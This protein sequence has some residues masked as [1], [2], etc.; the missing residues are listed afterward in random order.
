VAE[1]M[2]PLSKINKEGLQTRKAIDQATVDRYCEA[3]LAGEKLPAAIVFHDGKQNH[4]GD[5][6]HRD[7][8]YAKAGKKSMPVKVKKGSFS[9]ALHYSA[10]CNDTHG[11]P[12]SIEDRRNSVRIILAEKQDRSDN[13]VAKICHVSDGLVAKI[14]A[15]EFPPSQEESSGSGSNSGTSQGGD[16]GASGS[17]N[18]TSTEKRTGADG[19]QYSARKPK[20]L[21]ERCTRNGAQRDCPF[22]KELRKGGAGKPREPGDDSDTERKGRDAAKAN[23]KPAFDWKGALDYMG[24][25][26]RFPDVI[27]RAYPSVKG[28]KEHTKVSKC[29]DE[30][31]EIVKEWKK[32]LQEA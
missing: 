18:G 10:G 1:H 30:I 2:L 16:P 6:F 9:D 20:V 13:A 15:E 7:L 25:A 22:C 11:L 21:C 23:G 28:T 29:L 17:Q 8:A 19:K 12:R 14:R 4:M 24:K 26:Y 31:A 3:I 5:G 27:A 32:T